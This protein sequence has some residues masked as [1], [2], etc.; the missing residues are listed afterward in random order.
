MLRSVSVLSGLGADPTHLWMTPLVP[1]AADVGIIAIE[2]RQL[3]A[4]QQ[5]ALD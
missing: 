5:P 2:Q 4:L 3:G 1:A